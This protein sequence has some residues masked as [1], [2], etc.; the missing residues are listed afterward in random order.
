MSRLRFGIF[1]APF[2][3]VGQNPTLALDRDMELVEWLDHLGFDEA[4][5]GEHHSG[6]Y[7]CIA[8]PEIFIAA[9]AQRTR[10]IR[11]GTGVTSL[12]YHHPFHVADRW[13]QLD[14][15]TRGRCMF[16]VGPGAL[17]SDA[18]MLGIDYGQTRRRMQEGL[19]AIM[20]LLYE[21]EPVTLKSDWF[22]LQEAR[23]MFSPYS[24]KL[25]LA[26][27]SIASPAGPVTAGQ[28]GAGLLSLSATAEAAFDVLGSHYKIW[29]EAAAE[30]GQPP[31]DRSKWRVVAPVHLA[32]TREQAMRNVRYGIAPWVDYFTS[33]VA[34]S[35]T[36]ETDDPEAFARELVNTGFAVIG[37]PDDCCEMIARLQEQTGGFG[38]F[39]VMANDWADREATMK[40]YELMSKYV[41]PQ[42]QGSARRPVATHAWTQANYQNFTARAGDAVLS[43]IEEHQD[44]RKRKGLE[45]DDLDKHAASIRWAGSKQDPPAEDD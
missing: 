20:R 36:P 19:A 17:A 34:L 32:E 29:Q 11:L 4:W 38:S 5:I 28:C 21:D 10:H 12:P 41:F 23:L 3:P 6:G 37:T 43:A 35:F 13:V 9:A 42:F 16:G 8:C 44:E 25:D 18:H 31:A 27:A 26:I 39:L 22:E 30:A 15:M 45:S 1:T 24:E 33:V 2:H 40:S 14:H 7:E